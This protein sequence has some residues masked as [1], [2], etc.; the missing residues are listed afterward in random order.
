M[1][2]SG[3]FR[4]KRKR[5][6]WGTYDTYE[7]A[8]LALLSNESPRRMQ[9]PPGRSPEPIDA[10]PL[11]LG[12]DVL[13][14]ATPKLENFDLDDLTP[15]RPAPKLE[16]FDLVDLYSEYLYDTEPLSPE[17][18]LSDTWSNLPLEAP[19][20]DDE[21]SVYS[22][23]HQVEDFESDADEYVTYPPLDTL[24]QP[25]PSCSIA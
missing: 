17:P 16:D 22:L 10:E 21:G 23:N 8:E 20:S 3:R 9:P 7:E 14:G 15:D 18:L 1:T 24:N 2:E 11:G 19:R 6:H 4:A 5:T 13:S 25:Q 12:F